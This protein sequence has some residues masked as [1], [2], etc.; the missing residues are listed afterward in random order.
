MRT[1]S[2]GAKRRKRGV[3]ELSRQEEEKGGNI[4]QVKRRKKW[5]AG[6]CLQEME[7]EVEGLSRQRGGS[8]RAAADMNHPSIWEDK[9]G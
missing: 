4:A 8:I 9:A 3:R 5:S 1:E 6:K 7:V 2:E